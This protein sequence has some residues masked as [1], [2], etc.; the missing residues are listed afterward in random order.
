MNTAKV[1]DINTHASRDGK[2]VEVRP[3]PRALVGLKLRNEAFTCEAIGRVHRKDAGTDGFVRCEVYE[4]SIDW[5]KS[6]VEDKPELIEAAKMLFKAELIQYTAKALNVPANTLPD[7]IDSWNEKLSKYKQTCPFSLE[8]CFQKM[9]GRGMRPVIE[10]TVFK[11]GIPAPQ[12]IASKGAIEMV[13]A[14]QAQTNDGVVGLL[15][16]KLT[17]MQAKLDKLEDKSNKQA[18]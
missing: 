15:M 8:S 10:M 9:A 11:E 16:E 1:Y 14:M 4:S 2:D 3:E 6:N 18:K 12:D 13:K 5:L 17:A 7:D